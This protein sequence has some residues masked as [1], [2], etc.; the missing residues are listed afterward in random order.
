MERVFKLNSN[1]ELID[2]SGF[3]IM[4]NPEYRLPVLNRWYSYEACSIFDMFNYILQVC[5][6]KDDRL[7]NCSL[8]TGDDLFIEFY[9]LGHR[10]RNS[11][12][13]NFIDNYEVSNE[14][15]E[16]ITELVDKDRSEEFL[17]IVDQLFVNSFLS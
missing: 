10:I 16:Y 3:G 13:R 2:C 4:P 12:R 1:G 9:Y 7:I 15:M 14:M 5:P 8:G 11:L 17:N 6:V